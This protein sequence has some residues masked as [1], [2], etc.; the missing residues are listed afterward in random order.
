MMRCAPKTFCGKDLQQDTGPSFPGKFLL[1]LFRIYLLYK[2]DSLT[3]AWECRYLEKICIISLCDVVLG[4]M[5][6]VGKLFI[7]TS[8]VSLYLL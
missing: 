1:F 7:S 3:M 5:I 4:Y 2:Q 6:Y 8:F